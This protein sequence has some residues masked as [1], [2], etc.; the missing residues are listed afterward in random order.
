MSTNYQL[1][2]I[3]YLFLVVISVSGKEFE[4][5]HRSRRQLLFPNST[6]LQFNVGIG[7]PTPAA[8][9][10]LNYAFQANFQLPWNRSQIPFD[11]LE[12]YNGYTGSR[13]KRDVDNNLDVMEK[14]GYYDNDGRLYH[15]YNLGYN[16]TSCVFRTLCQLGSEPL[17]SEDGEDLLHELATYV[18][19]P[20]NE[21]YHPDYHHEVQPY[22]EAYEHGEGKKDCVSLYKNCPISLIDLFSKLY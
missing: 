3:C 19:N 1:I 15:F 9:V 21:M 20:R 8:L 10:N 2:L 18:L 5:I 22:I 13:K 17:H 4:G 16:G 12:A 6:L 7:T 14:D 11:V